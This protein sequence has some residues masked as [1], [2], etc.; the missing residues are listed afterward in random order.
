MDDHT[1][2]SRKFRNCSPRLSEPSTSDCF[3]RLGATPTEDPEEELE[4]Y[5]LEAKQAYDTLIQMGGRPTRP[6]RPTPS[7]K[8][9]LVG[10]ELCYRYAEQVETLFYD[11]WYG[12]EPS[13]NISLTE[14]DFIAGH[15]REERGRY[16]EELRRWQE[17][18]DTQQWRRKHRPDFAKEEDTER[19]RYPHDPQ[20]TASL[21]KRTDWKEYQ[22][23]FQKGIDRLKRGMKGDRRAVE[24]IQRKDAEVDWSTGL[25]KFRGLHHEG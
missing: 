15:W 12:Y 25:G 16:K 6:I 19:Q 21:K 4:R 22:A 20:L 7:W 14:A 23:Y 1:D 11:I 18:L 9:V 3:S 10:G 13:P 5:K 17:F 24:A 2:A 8:K